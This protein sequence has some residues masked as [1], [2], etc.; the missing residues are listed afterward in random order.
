MLT[1]KK[2]FFE[3]LFDRGT[4][5][6]RRMV[7]L[8]NDRNGRWVTR[9]WLSEKLGLSKRMTL[10]VISS[11]AEKIADLPSEKFSFQQSKGKGV[12]LVV[13]LDADV[14][15]LVTEIVRN[16]ST[17]VLLRALIVGEFDSVRNYAMQHFISESTVRRDLTKVQKL[18]AR[19]QLE[20]E[21]ENFQLQGEEYQIRMFMVI[22]FWSIYRGSSWPFSYVDEQ[23]IDEY[24]EEV[25]N[26]EFTVY[27]NIPYTYKKQ[28]A[29]IFAETIIRTRKGNILKMPAELENQITANALYPGF[30]RIMSR[31]QGTLN[32]KQAEIPFFFL[33]WVSMSKTI[34]VFKEAIVDDLFQQQKN[35]ETEIFKATEL[36]LAR[37]QDEFFPIKDEDYLRFRNYILSSHFF[38]MYFKGFN[39][40]MTGNTYH[41]IFAERYPQLI[42]KTDCFVEELYA[43]SKNPIFL[44]KEFLLIPYLK[45]ILFFD[46][47]CK[48]EV[49]MTMLVE[50]DMPSLMTKSF[51][52]QLRGYFSYLYNVTITDIF[53]TS[54]Q[55][56]DVLL[57][58]GILKD[59]KKAY[60][61]A[62][63]VVVSK[64]LSM[65]DLARINQVL[66]EIS[67]EK[68]KS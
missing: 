64:K 28:L 51:I 30:E 20:V 17:V 38:A 59:L 21:R 26:S 47:P 45:N 10:S 32:T 19:Y 37:F 44:E 6:Q 42:E 62:Q 24:V 43:E 16:C 55:H 1:T 56:A 18:L 12:R 8:L 31:H 11:L 35:Q 52:R 29:Y 3:E 54:N 14:Y 40:D 50:S 33:V 60:S 57:T 68:R 4:F 39:T 2:D 5:H 27:P 63:V 13:A 58:T 67:A 34:E 36:M 41:S 15:Y 48:Y 46:A 23:L 61:E 9:E 25:L 7:L 53:E 66:E 65:T 22:F 49:P